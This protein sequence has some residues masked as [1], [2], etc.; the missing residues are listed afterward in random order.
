MASSV[1]R[2]EKKP[3]CSGGLLEVASAT[4]YFFEALPEALMTVTAS[5][6]SLLFAAFLSTS[7]KIG[8]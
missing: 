7:P 3:A 1:T 4:G 6:V 2:H 5:A 8:Q